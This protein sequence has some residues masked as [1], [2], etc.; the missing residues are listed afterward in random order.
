MA[1]LVFQGDAEN[2]GRGRLGAG[3]SESIAW[4]GTQGAR[5]AGLAPGMLRMEHPWS[6]GVPA[7][8]HQPRNPRTLGE[9]LHPCL[10]ITRGQLAV[11]QEGTVLLGSPQSCCSSRGTRAGRGCQDGVAMLALPPRPHRRCVGNKS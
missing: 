1:C 3:S 7:G 8:S 4:R 9:E 11:S 10:S 6:T 2:P 5:A